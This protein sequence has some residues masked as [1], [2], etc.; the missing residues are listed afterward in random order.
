MIRKIVLTRDY[1]WL[2]DG[3]TARSFAPT[4]AGLESN[5]KTAG[6]DFDTSLFDSTANAFDLLAVLSGIALL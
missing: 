4:G 2:R 1:E 3:W 6:M 5:I